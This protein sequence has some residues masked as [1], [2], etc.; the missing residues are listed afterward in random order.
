MLMRV[1][2][3]GK[4]DMLWAGQE[5]R[6]VDPIPLAWPCQRTRCA[7]G[8]GAVRHPHHRG[9]QHGVQNRV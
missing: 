9:K 6:R 7:L 3:A 1:T 2:R 4:P 8:M 5:H